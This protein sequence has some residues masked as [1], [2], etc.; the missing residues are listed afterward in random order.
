[1]TKKDYYEILGVKKGS[2]KDEIKK[3]YKKLAMKYHPDVSKDKDSEAKFKE[4][5]EAYAVLSDDTKKQQYDSF[6]HAGF[7]QRYSQEDI[8][9]GADFGSIFEDLFGGNFGG[10]DSF[11]GGGRQR[12]GHDLEKSMTINFEEAVFGAEKEITV[13][14]Y[15]ECDSCK[16]TGAKDSKLIECPVCHGEGHSKRTQRTPFG[17]FQT[18]TNCRNCNSSGEVP[19]DLCSNC[20]G[21]GVENKSDEIKVKIP[22][23]IDDEQILKIKG[24]GEYLKNGIPGDLFLHINVKQHKIFTRKENDIYLDFPISFS[25]AA[26]GDEVEI[27]TLDE[28]VKMKIPQG[29]QSHTLFRL[30]N[31]GVEGLNGYGQGDQF[32]R[33]IV[34][35]PSKLDKQQK[36]FFDKLAKENKEKL[37]IE[38]GF[39][40]K[41]KDVFG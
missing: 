8:F 2:S 9:R 3:S 26:L 10:F 24:E 23:G 28:E 13:K 32:V 40:D 7:D 39:F 4:I 20:H 17:V 5:S 14:K 35:T 15:S 22:K 12:K 11:F 16:G 34:K 25:Q 6:G 41:V 1:M 29:T 27:P 33:V 30:K 18:T 31:K 36:E 19:K 21:Y 37:K 38:K